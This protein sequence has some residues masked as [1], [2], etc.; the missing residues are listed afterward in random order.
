LDLFPSFN[1][2][3]TDRFIEDGIQDKDQQDEVGHLDEQKGTDT[4]HEELPLS[5]LEGL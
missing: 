1:E 4:D 5:N 3:V 2:Y